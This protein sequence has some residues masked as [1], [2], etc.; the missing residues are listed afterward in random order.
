MG[1]EKG[2]RVPAASNCIWGFPTGALC[3]SAPWFGSGRIDRDR[4]PITCICRTR[5]TRLDMDA[6]SLVKW[7]LMK[8]A[9][10][11]NG[12]LCTVAVLAAR[13]HSNT[14][15]L[16]AIFCMLCH[17]VLTA[18]ISP[19]ASEDDLQVVLGCT[20]RDGGREHRMTQHAENGEEGESVAVNTRS[21]HCNSA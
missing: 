19:S 20:G 10:A 17:P 18:A 5:W 2:R 4:R 8:R 11:L 16:L 21:Q 1:G 7:R 6:L 13:I 3:I 9:A 12:L 15:S 14:F